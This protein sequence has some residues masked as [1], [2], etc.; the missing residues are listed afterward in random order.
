SLSTINSPIASRENV[1]TAAVDP[2]NASGEPCRFNKSKCANHATTAGASNER[3][4]AT[5]PIPMA[6]RK[7]LSMHD[8]F[9][10]QGRLRV[11]FR[12]TE[13]W[14]P[15]LHWI[16]LVKQENYRS[17]QMTGDALPESQDTAGRGRANANIC[18]TIQRSAPIDPLGSLGP[19]RDGL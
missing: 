15:N 11:L 19:G 4:P 13:S 18:R 12:A 16:C 1:A 5:I 17:K 9:L 10:K 14:L 6:N 7:T 3:S 8:S 2:M